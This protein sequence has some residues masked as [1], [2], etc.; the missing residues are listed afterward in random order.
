MARV[1][2]PRPDVGLA[3]LDESRLALLLAVA[4]ADA[5]WSEVMPPV[6]G[7]PDWTDERRAAFLTMHRDSFGAGADLDRQVMFAVLRSSRVVGMV[8]LA[9]I[10]DHELVTGMWLARSERQSGVGS[11]ALALAID[12][13]RRVGASAVVADTTA[14]NHAAQRVLR[15]LGFHLDHAAD[16]EKVFARLVLV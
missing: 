11:A 7:D 9:P 12:E 2:T 3:S 13:A 4:E 15:R 1:E 8:R 5:H 6:A 10:E 14:G 16:A